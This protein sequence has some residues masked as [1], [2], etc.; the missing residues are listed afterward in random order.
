M[1]VPLSVFTA[2]GAAALAARLNASAAYRV[3]AETWEGSLLLEVD[4]AEGSPPVAVFLDLW[5]GECRAA[6]VANPADREAAS[7]VLAAPAEIWQTLLAGR[8]DVL[9][10]LFGRRLRLER[11]RLL[12][13]TP[14]LEA[15]RQL[16]AAAMEVNGTELAGVL[17]PEPAADS[18]DTVPEKSVRRARFQTTSGQGLDYS[19]PALK[20]WTKAKRHGIWDPF[21]IDFV[22]D[23]RDWE[24][25]GSLE[26]EVVLHLTSQFQAGEESVTL[27]LLPLISVIAREGRLEEEIYLTS[28]LW[29]EAKHVELFRR[30]LDEVA[31]E[32]GDLAGFHG[33]AYRRVFYEE[34]PRAL[35]RLNS[36]P[37]VEAQAEASVT[38]N[39]IV[40]G[41][42]AETGYH[43]YQRMLE[44]N[45]LMPGMQ[46]AIGNLRRDE[47]RHIAYGVFLLSRLVA[48]HGDTAWFAIDRRM[49]ELLPLS[50]ESVREV[51]DR[52]EVMPFGLEVG[53]FV[54]FATKQFE[55]RYARIER[56]RGQS[57]EDLFGPNDESL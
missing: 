3:A 32:A 53:Q 52:Y 30:F 45:G 15:A 12:S 16:V 33:P 35:G 28:F 54:D 2:E 48:E 26:R 4:A 44:E 43:A 55:R 42:L 39:M 25:L 27:D 37:S 57:L 8:L 9:T 17:R 6:R 41:V 40:E 23:R 49:S 5:H 7:Y 24:A 29:E 31:R 46:Q 18:R 21:S 1:T 36:D 19:H 51:F 34:L 20:L 38:Y 14:Y 11:G 50:V 22:Q 10:A 56:A 13:L 47:S